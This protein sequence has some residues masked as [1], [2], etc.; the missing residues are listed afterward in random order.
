MN[1]TH[2]KYSLRPKK[3]VSFFF[4]AEKSSSKIIPSYVNMTILA[5]MRETHWVCIFLYVLYSILKPKVLNL[6]LGWR[7]VNKEKN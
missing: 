3:F 1:A 4:G 7:F 6:D 5:S 2:G